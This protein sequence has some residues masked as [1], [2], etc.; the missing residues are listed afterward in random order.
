MFMLNCPVL[1]NLSNDTL[2]YNFSLTCLR[3]LELSELK[4]GD[5]PM[6]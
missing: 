3:G 1:P 5:M 6:V 2:I 4:E